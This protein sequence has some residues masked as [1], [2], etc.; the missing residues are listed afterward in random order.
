MFNTCVKCCYETFAEILNQMAFLNLGLCSGRSASSLHGHSAASRRML[1]LSTAGSQQQQ[2]LL[3]PCQPPSAA[4]AARLL[5]AC[6]RK[7]CTELADTQAQLPI[8]NSEQ[9][10]DRRRDSEGLQPCQNL[11]GTHHRFGGCAPFCQKQ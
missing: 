10:W 11:S 5:A 7:A 3:L 4:R 6:A 9:D 8:N 1:S 2:T